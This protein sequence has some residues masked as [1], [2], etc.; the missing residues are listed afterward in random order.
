MAHLVSRRLSFVDDIEL[1]CDWR[2]VD[3]QERCSRLIPADMKNMLTLVTYGFALCPI[4]TEAWQECQEKGRAPWHTYLRF[5][6]IDELLKTRSLCCVLPGCNRS[7]P[8]TTANLRRYLETGEIYCLAHDA[9]TALA[10]ALELPHERA[11]VLTAL[12]E[13][14][15][16]PAGKR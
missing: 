11:L 4:H 3:G 6:R 9:V 1:T 16:L 15:A 5:E 7:V 13:Q 8:R 14:I 12:A 10:C 2:G